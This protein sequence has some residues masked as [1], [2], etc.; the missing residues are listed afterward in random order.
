MIEG[1]ATV[2]VGIVAFFLLPSGPISVD[3]G[4]ELTLR[5]PGL[6]QVAHTRGEAPRANPPG[7]P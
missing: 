4:Q 7:C 3:E 6:D 2:V 5:F 1:M